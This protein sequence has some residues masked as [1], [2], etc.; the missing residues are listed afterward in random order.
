LGLYVSYCF[1]QSTFRSS[2]NGYLLWKVFHNDSK[3]FSGSRS[4]M[5]MW[6]PARATEIK[7]SD[8]EAKQECC[9]FESGREIGHQLYSEFGDG[10][11]DGVDFQGVPT[12]E[13]KRACYFLWRLEA[14]LATHE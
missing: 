3:F 9:G 1:F 2:K 11:L 8:V 10:K 14:A 6:I 13:A 5:A 7:K 12:D 4:M